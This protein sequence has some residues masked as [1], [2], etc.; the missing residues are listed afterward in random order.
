MAIARNE[1]FTFG[2][3]HNEHHIPFFSEIKFITV[4]VGAE[5]D[6]KLVW[7]YNHTSPNLLETFLL[8][9]PQMSM[10]HIADAPLPKLNCHL[11]LG[12]GTVDYSAYSQK[13]VAHGFDGVGILEIGGTP[14][15]GGFGQDTDEALIQ[16]LRLMQETGATV[17]DHDV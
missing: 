4:L 7:D 17:V 13:V 14:W 2:I 12:E 3:E 10:L 11:P 5:P 9:A 16:S 1:G 6:L 15:S 8:L